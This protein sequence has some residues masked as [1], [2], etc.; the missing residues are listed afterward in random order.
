MPFVQNLKKEICNALE[1]EVALLVK[2]GWKVLTDAE[3]AIHRELLVAKPELTSAAS[4]EAARLKVGLYDALSQV[5]KVVK[6]ETGAKTAT[7]AK[8]ATKAPAAAAPAK[9]ATV[10]PADPVTNTGGDTTNA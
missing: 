5:E 10:A 8:T 3:E 2:K 1:P 6:A 9:T 4:Q 7:P